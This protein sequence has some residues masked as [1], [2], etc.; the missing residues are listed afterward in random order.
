MKKIFLPVLLAAVAFTNT[1][2]KDYLE[3]ENLFNKNL[4]SFYSTPEEVEQAIAGVYVSMYTVFNNGNNDEALAANVLDDI[5]LG[6]GS[7]SDPSHQHDFFKFDAVDVYR[8]GWKEAYNGIYRANAIIE[9]L[10]SEGFNLDEFFPTPEAAD[11][12]VNQILGEAYFMRG[13]YYLRQG[14]MFG[15]VP[16]IP[17]TSSD[18][19]VPRAT[20]TET[21]TEAA[22]NFMMAIKTL[23]NKGM[24][25]YGLEDY[26]HANKWAAQGMLARTYL[27]YVG[28][29]TNME[30]TATDVL[31]LAEYAGGGDLTKD[32]VVAELNDCMA[33]SGYSLTPDFRNLWPY[34]YV[35]AVSEQIGDAAG[36]N[37]LPWAA[38]NGLAWVGQDGPHSAIGT[39]N[40][41]SMFVVRYGFGDWQD[42]G[43]YNQ[44][45]QFM[46]CGDGG[47]LFEVGWGWGPVHSSFATDWKNVDGD[48]RYEGTILEIGDAKKCG[49]ALNFASARTDHTGFYNMKYTS[50][51]LTNKD[52]V[53]NGIFPFIYDFLTVDASAIAH[54]QDFISLRYADIL[55][56]HSELTGDAAGMNQVRERAG[57]APVAYSLDAIKTERL[58]EFAYEASRYY[59]LVR[60]GDLYKSG[61]ATYYDNEIDV[62]GATEGKYSVTMDASKKGLFPIPESEVSIS[63]GVY[64]QNPGW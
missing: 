28:Y 2:C 63:N 7:S 12:F 19:N 34:S 55:L 10:T 49:D 33:N 26:G 15:G 13:Y 21:F 30:G 45:C 23:P 3:A 43:H 24:A 57:L 60:W 14:R 44:S 36:A 17:T 27:H 64:E 39:G 62:K 37:K 16:I 9:K 53:H 31:P 46:G 25:E 42:G 38:D 50:L 47:G 4:D 52:G 18:R 22:S 35:N 32:A 59:D 5:C 8:D 20:Y 61:T 29:M 54:A 51:A 41:E 48:I 40:Y 11:E 1:S 6:G 56:M 58:Y